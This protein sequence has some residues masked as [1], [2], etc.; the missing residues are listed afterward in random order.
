MTI[1]GVSV[2]GPDDQIATNDYPEAVALANY[3]NAGY[4]AI[5]P[6]PFDDNWPLV[7]A[8]PIEWYGEP[9]S[10][11]ADLAAPSVDY[12]AALAHVRSL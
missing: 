6:K 11:A 12:A 4:A 1:Y 10:H 8:S 7:W 9:A 2:R 5:M 3:L